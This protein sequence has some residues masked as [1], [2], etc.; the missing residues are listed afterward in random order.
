[1]NID[2]L[3]I[4]VIVG[5]IAGIL[6]DAVWGGMKIGI[7]GAIVIGILGAI[8]GGWLFDKLDWQIFTGWWD[9]VLKPVIGAVILLVIIGVLRRD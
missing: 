8:I 5:A 6:V 9:M 1:M 2:I 4:W 3:M 7:V